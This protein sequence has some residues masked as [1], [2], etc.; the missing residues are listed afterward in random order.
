MAFTEADLRSMGLEKRTDGSYAK[1]KKTTAT[2]KKKEPVKTKR[3]G[4]IFIPGHVPSLKNSKRILQ[5]NG[6]DGRKIPFIASSAAVMKYKKETKKDYDRY[7][8]VFHSLLRDL[9]PP[10]YVEFYFIRKTRHKFD[11][12]NANHMVTD[13]MVEHG[14]LLDDDIDTILPLPPL[15]Q[16]IYEHSKTNPGVWIT[17]KK[18]KA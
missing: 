12:N 13:M 7:R 14:W 18:Y 16:P 2:E 10:Y 3:T 11:F 17:V 8:N 1:K 9:H 5:R 6:K 15:N 4:H